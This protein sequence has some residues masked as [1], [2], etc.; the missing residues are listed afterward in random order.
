MKTHST[1]HLEEIERLKKVE[2]QIRGIIRMIE[3]H[4][5]CI[6]ILTQL[7]AVQGALARI[8][9]SILE[10]HLKSCVAESFE[11]ATLKE[12]TAK[13]NEIITLLRKTRR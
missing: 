5:Y 9:E 8:Q 3:E 6:D 11:A 2:G 1:T 7:A 10:R 4:R 13:I 12:R